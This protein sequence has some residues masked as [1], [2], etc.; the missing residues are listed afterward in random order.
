MRLKL[1]ITI[2]LASAVAGQNQT[3]LQQILANPQGSTKLVTILNNLGPDS[4]VIQNLNSTNGNYTV[5]VPSDNAFQHAS[6]SMINQTYGNF[7][8]VLLYHVVDQRI[9]TT[10]NVTD[11]PLFVGT[12]LTNKSVNRYEDGRGLPIGL[13]NSGQSSQSTPQKRETILDVDNQDQLTK[14]QTTTNNPQVQ[15]GYADG[16]T[17]NIQRANI[18]ASNG[19][20]HYIDQV[21]MPPT[22]PVDTL[23]T[24]QFLST[25]YHNVVGLN[26]NDTLGAA[27]AVSENQFTFVN[28]F[29]INRT[30]SFQVTIFA[31]TD[32][33]WENANITQYSNDTIAKILRNHV[34]D[35]VYF[36]S[37][38]T[39]S[40]TL[41][42]FDKGE[43]TFTNVSGTV[44]SN[45]STTTTAAQRPNKLT[46][47][48]FDEN[49]NYHYMIDNASIVDANL[50]TDN[51]VIHAIDQVLIPE[52]VAQ[53]NNGNSGSGS[54]SDANIT[55]PSLIALFIAVSISSLII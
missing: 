3:I 17:A 30:F 40:S 11:I 22:S 36:T 16:Q 28:T 6:P 43:L 46:N 9:N 8:N 52:E 39:N 29:G 10:T 2:A 20:I 19:I 50:L 25:N 53:E 24:Q 33:A 54:S 14:R 7:E 18:P 4:S 38:I 44:N 21:M 49:T 37:N 23:Q 45:E 42:T 47:H 31:P 13:A 1:L 34:V 55:S 5:F 51:G 41:T 27:N 26:F 32:E 35:G 12:M 48:M 15:V